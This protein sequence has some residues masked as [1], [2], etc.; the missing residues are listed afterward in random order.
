[1][2]LMKRGANVALTR[3]IPNLTGLV[4]GVRFTAGAE[5]VLLENMVM[6]TILC[7]ADNQA[8]SDDHF[9]FFNQL[10]SPD[11]SVTQLEKAVGEDT[12]QVEIDLASVP[13]EVD[14]IAVVAYLN[15]AIAA[16]RTMGQLKECTVRVLNLQGN[17][18]LVRS[19]NLA[20]GLSA[21]TALVLGEVY[22]N[23]ADWKF[24]VIGAGY[25]EGIA[26]VARDYGVGL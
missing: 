22:R 19:E 10:R 16:R 12:E 1:M 23:G 7:D 2:A 5:H 8:L 14:R 13:A 6:A 15:E 4:V 21:E 26:A 18:E 17:T 9:V 25:A 24:K 3:E 11:L 20:T